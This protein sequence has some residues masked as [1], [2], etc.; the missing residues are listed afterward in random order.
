MGTEMITGW[1]NNGNGKGTQ[2]IG[3]KEIKV[4][5]IQVRKLFLMSERSRKRVRGMMDKYYMGEQYGIKEGGSY[6][7]NKGK[8]CKKSF[9]PS[10]A[11]DHVLTVI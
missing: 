4:H 8:E 10:S 3:Q 1:N 7:G 5:K 11:T 2:E 6:D 9:S